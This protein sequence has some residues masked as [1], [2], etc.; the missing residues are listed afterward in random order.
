MA[1]KYKRKEIILKAQKNHLSV[2]HCRL[3]KLEREIPPQYLHMV[4][5]Y[6]QGMA[7]VV[8]PPP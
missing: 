4:S 6:W 1:G 5:I 3:E 7:G 2:V 8:I